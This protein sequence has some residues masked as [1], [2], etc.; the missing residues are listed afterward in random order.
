[1]VRHS[2]NDLSQVRQI[3]LVGSHACARLVLTPCPA[4]LVYYVPSGLSEATYSQLKAANDLVPSG[5]SIAG[6][7]V[8]NHRLFAIG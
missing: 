2:V 6:T 8:P 1:M 4:M 3:R 7:H 5:K